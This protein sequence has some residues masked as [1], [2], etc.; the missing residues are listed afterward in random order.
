MFFH[1]STCTLYDIVLQILPPDHNEILNGLPACAKANA[2]GP[3]K[4]NLTANY[5]NYANNLSS[6]SEGITPKSPK[7]D[8]FS[9]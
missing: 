4:I 7:G 9:P 6:D 5:A 2:P 8:F 3:S 1:F